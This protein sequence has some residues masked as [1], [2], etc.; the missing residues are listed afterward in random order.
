MR[1]SAAAGTNGEALLEEHDRGDRRLGLLHCW[2]L[3]EHENGRFERRNGVV[4]DTVWLHLAD[5]EEAVEH[6]RET[7][8]MALPEIARELQAGGVDAEPEELE[9]MHVDIALSDEVEAELRL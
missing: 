9:R 1:E 6:A 5:R 3:V 7:F 2:A 8:E 4:I